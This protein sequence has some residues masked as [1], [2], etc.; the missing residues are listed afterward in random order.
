MEFIN[1]T[2]IAFYYFSIYFKF[3]L[4]QTINF[5]WNL[6]LRWNHRNAFRLRTKCV[7]EGVVWVWVWVCGCLL[8]HCVSAAGSVPISHP[9][10]ELL[11]LLF[12]FISICTVYCSFSLC[13]FSL[14]LPF[15]II[16]PEFLFILCGIEAFPPVGDKNYFF[17]VLSLP[18]RNEMWQGLSRKSPLKREMDSIYAGFHEF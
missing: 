3:I 4:A 8:C 9:P 1:K 10:L 6:S 5:N 16:L 14:S 15:F 2:R 18:A 13:Y 17:A 12:F 11:S 7:W